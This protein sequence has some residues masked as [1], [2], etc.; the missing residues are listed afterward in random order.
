MIQGIRFNIYSS[1]SN[2][3]FQDVYTLHI[4]R[5]VFML[6]IGHQYKVSMDKKTGYQAVQ[7][8]KH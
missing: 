6:D 2:K 3:F 8:R 4:E 1:I 7:I 5:Y